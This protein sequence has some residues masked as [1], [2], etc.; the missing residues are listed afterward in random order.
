MTP[1]HNDIKYMAHI[2]KEL[3]EER[4]GL[5]TL[6]LRLRFLNAA[7]ME[8]HLDGCDLPNVIATSR[9]T[10]TENTIV[11]SEDYLKTEAATKEDI[12]CT[13]LHEIAHEFHT[14]HPEEFY[15]LLETCGI[16][17]GDYHTPTHEQRSETWIGK[18]PC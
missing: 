7:W 14:G 12:F 18:L 16:R 15:D 6:P 8:A 2:A 10:S 9:R 11:I 13:L 4:T 17:I 1:S 3:F 5:T